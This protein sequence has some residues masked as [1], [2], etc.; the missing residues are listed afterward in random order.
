MAWHGIQGRGRGRGR[1][2]TGKS[3][4]DI[5]APLHPVLTGP[6]PTFRERHKFTA[7]V[8]VRLICLPSP[9][10]RLLS[11]APTT[12]TTPYFT[13]ISIRCFLLLK[14]RSEF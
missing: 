6:R 11:P 10:S 3:A 13:H 4:Y 1:G 5:I 9:V 2:V 14:S 7:S 8:S 12:P